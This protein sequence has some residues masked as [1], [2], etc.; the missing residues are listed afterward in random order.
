[1]SITK[2]GYISAIDDKLDAFETNEKPVVYPID[3]DNHLR[4]PADKIFYC[5]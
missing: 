3:K 1:V 5:G 2:E 4:Q